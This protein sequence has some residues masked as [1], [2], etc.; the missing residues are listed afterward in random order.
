[1]NNLCYLILGFLIVG[2]NQYQ[3]YIIRNIRPEFFLEECLRE[4]FLAVKIMIDEKRIVNIL[5]IQDA[6]V[7][8]L[9]S[10]VL[11]KRLKSFMTYFLK[12]GILK[13]SC[14]E[15]AL[16]AQIGILLCEITN[17][18][19]F[20]IPLEIAVQCFI[21]QYV[22]TAKQKIMAEYQF[23]LKNNPA[24]EYTDEFSLRM[25]ELD[26]L[27][28]HESWKEYVLDLA[29]IE[30]EPDED[31]L[32]YRKG[33]GY[34]WRGNLYL[35]SGYAGSMKSFLCL[36]IAS[37]ALNHGTGAER[38][39]SFYSLS[40]PLKVLYADTELAPNTV[41][42]RI[43]SLKVMTGGMHNTKAF[44]YLSLRKVP[45]G[46]DARKK[47]LNEACQ[48][49]CPDIIIIDSARDLCYDYNDNREADKLVD[50]LKQIATDHNAIV[51]S[52]SHKSLGAGNAKGHFGVRMNEAAGLEMSLIKKTD[53]NNT[54]IRVEYPKQRE[55]LYDEFSF[56]LDP[57]SGL[58]LEYAP[59]V[60]HAEER[61]QFLKAES[62]VRAVLRPGETVRYNDLKLRIMEKC[63][64][65]DG[66]A[67]NY[68]SV[69]VGTILSN[70]EDG[71]YHL[72]DAENGLPLDDDLPQN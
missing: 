63:P 56:K 36:C 14:S 57:K 60:D 44:M 41:K 1:M 61:R 68:I 16:K 25:R 22:S 30:L 26:N 64:I 15:T 7:T 9:N 17:E 62:S 49:F 69:L 66:T 48:G 55:D 31:A 23:R 43:K 37:A 42:K 35:I 5:S 20:T 10:K 72:S 59:T 33:Q 3:M 18:V 46:I 12:K 13:G 2:S 65:S 50:H 47:V 6:I 71:L 38:V 24:G 52:T 54:Y 51:I 21:V 45:G 19:N 32:I 27:L 28:S 40:M 11:E 34:M 58:L 70:D 29:K 8:D 39:L 4:I 67:K 53:G